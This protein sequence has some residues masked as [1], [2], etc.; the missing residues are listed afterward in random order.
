MDVDV[1]ECGDGDWRVAKRLIF[2]ARG[3][4]GKTQDSVLVQEKSTR[5]SEDGSTM[6]WT[7]DS[8]STEV[9]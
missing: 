2:T 5:P 1:K 6:H 8:S 4:V 3:V 7:R 9:S